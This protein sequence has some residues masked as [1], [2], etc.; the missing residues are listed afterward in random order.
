MGVESQE[1]RNEQVVSIP[2]GL[3]RLLT[4]TGVSSGIHEHH[5]EQHDMAS[6]ATRL[7]VMDLQSS[8]RTDLSLLDVVEVDIVS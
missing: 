8:D 3:E 4:D 7:G 2:E 5:A 1:K 6:N